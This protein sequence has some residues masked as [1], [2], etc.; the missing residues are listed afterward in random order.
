MATRDKVG[1]L[2][3][4]LHKLRFDYSSQQALARAGSS[5]IY[6]AGMTSARSKEISR[7]LAQGVCVSSVFVRHVSE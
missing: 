1:Q 5:S 7:Q 4:K 6:T 3:S 2:T